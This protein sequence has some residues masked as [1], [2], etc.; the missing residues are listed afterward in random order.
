MRGSQGIRVRC[1][2]R[3]VRAPLPRS[4]APISC[5]DVKAAVEAEEAREKQAEVVW[6]GS[7]M[8]KAIGE[9]EGRPALDVTVSKHPQHT[10]SVPMCM[11]RAVG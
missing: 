11:Q 1:C 7:C 9:R 4:S 6:G 2:P 5:S 10:A 8:D 3:E